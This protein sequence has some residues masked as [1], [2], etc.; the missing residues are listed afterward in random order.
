MIDQR[1]RSQEMGVNTDIF[2]SA[3]TD[4]SAIES[5][6]AGRIQC[7]LTSPETILNKRQARDMLLIISPP[8]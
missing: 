3:Q 1:R 7:V 2:G 8:Y 5:I 6:F 4:K